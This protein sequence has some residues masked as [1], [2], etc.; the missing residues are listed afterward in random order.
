MMSW[1][2]MGVK[3]KVS[4]MIIDLQKYILKLLS[5]QAKNCFI[6]VNSKKAKTTMIMMTE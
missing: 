2:L 3:G 5:R 1:P 6:K 4:K